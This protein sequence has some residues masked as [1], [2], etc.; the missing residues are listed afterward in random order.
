VSLEHAEFWSK[1]ARKYDEVVDL[2]IGLTTRSRVRERLAR[3]G[4]LGDI[5]EFGCGT[6][7]YTETLAAK[8]N[9]LTAT[10]LSPGM[11]ALAR[12]RIQATNVTFQVED[13][14][15][16]SFADAAFDTVF[17]SLVLHFTEPQAALAE[18]CRILE[19]GGILIMVNLDPLALNGL[20]R[21]R[22]LVRV[23]FHGFIGY[24]TKPPKGFAKHVLT[25]QR[26]CALLRQ[27]GFEVASTETIKDPSRAS[28]IPVEYI[29][30]RRA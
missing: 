19:P 23:L 28:N 12:Q 15:R 20:D 17:M 29:K 25:E 16:T 8:A 5:V 30:A 24:R 6:G 3:E 7:F 27:C 2:Q 1:V 4:R 21:I 18:M 11:L 14:Q 13:C 9:A 26:L 10:D 22:C